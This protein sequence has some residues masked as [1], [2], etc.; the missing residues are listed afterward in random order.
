MKRLVLPVVIAA[1]AVTAFLFRDRWLPQPPGQLTYLGYVEGETVLIGAPQAGRLTA[2]NAVKGSPVQAGDRLFTLDPAVLE[3]E[4]AKE[5]LPWPRRRRHTA[6]FSPASA[7][8]NSRS[9]APGS[10]RRK[11]HSI[12]P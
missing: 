5:R 10:I 2:V 4:F 3:A 8:R 12:L 6:I 9:S 11:P 1:V 7:N